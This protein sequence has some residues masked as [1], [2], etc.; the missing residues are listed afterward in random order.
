MIILNLAECFKISRILAHGFEAR[1][2]L[3]EN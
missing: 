1:A 2:L 3:A